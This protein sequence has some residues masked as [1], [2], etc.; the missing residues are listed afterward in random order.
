MSEIIVAKKIK[1]RTELLAL[2]QNQKKEGKTDIAEFI[3][4]RG[5]KIVA[6]ILDSAWEME[7]FKERIKTE[8]IY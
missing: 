6:K 3:V 2:A 7:T 4:N 8:L 1:S 5:S